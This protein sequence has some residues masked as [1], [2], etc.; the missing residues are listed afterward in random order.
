MKAFEVTVT[1]SSPE[2]KLQMNLDAAHWM[3]AWKMAMSELGL[4]V[5]DTSDVRCE[6]RADGAVEVSVP[7][8]HGRRFLVSAAPCPET[9]TQEQPAPPKAAALRPSI[10]IEE[11]PAIGVADQPITRPL[12]ARSKREPPPGRL[13]PAVYRLD[14]NEESI[15]RESISMIA[16]HAPAE[17]ALFLVPNQDRSGWR[18]ALSQGRHSEALR[19]LELSSSEPLPGPVNRT[20][21]RRR[22]NAPVTLTFTGSD[23]APLLVTVSSAL[24]ST[25]RVDGVLRGLF[26][27][28]NAARSD[29]FTHN[30][31]EAAQHVA[32]LVTSRLSDD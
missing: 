16:G 23:N 2:P 29:G 24:W 5:L 20:S 13:Y 19:H 3:D 26:L 15:L 28:L 1:T 10:T 22:L 17:H 12:M 7:D 27:L 11:M 32:T 25:V 21:G 9:T 4:P 6:I 8:Q 31:F 14:G 18:I 30:E